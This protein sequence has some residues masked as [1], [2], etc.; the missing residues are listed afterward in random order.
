MIKKFPSNIDI[1]IKIFVPI[2]PSES[3]SKVKEAINLVMGSKV[4]YRNHSNN[5]ILG[6]TNRV[7]LLNRTYDQVRNRAVTSVFHR[8]LISNLNKNTTWFYI[9]KQ[10][11]TKGLI[12]L[13]EKF[14]EAPLGPIKISIS[15]E[16]ILE[17]ID[18]LSIE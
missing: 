8:L 16:N 18:W 12:V 2:F 17:V 1:E 4:E 6:I 14:P 9:N 3:V 15:S 11:A 13:V 5:L 7:E 10:A